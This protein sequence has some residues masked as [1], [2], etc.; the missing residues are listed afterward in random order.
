MFQKRCKIM[1]E[2]TTLGTTLAVNE[3]HFPQISRRTKQQ[4]FTY[5]KTIIKLLKIEN[6]FTISHQITDWPTPPK[7]L[8]KSRNFKPYLIILKHKYK[9]TNYNDR[10][11]SFTL[12]SVKQLIINCII[13]NSIYSQLHFPLFKSHS[14]D[15]W[16][17]MI[18][19]RTR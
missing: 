4:L 2:Q 10:F 12:E 3:Y 19:D 1:N 18:N 13:P 8:N 6:H 16:N 17:R 9:L 15:K 5:P 7:A 14:N 11:N